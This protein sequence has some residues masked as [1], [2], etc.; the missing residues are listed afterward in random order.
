MKKL[1]RVTETVTENDKNY[2]GFNF[3]DKVDEKILLTVA[4]GKFTLKGIT[5]KA[6]RSSLPDKKPWQISKI[7][8]RLRLHG[9]I[10]KVGKTYK[11]Y[12]TGLGKQAIVAGLSFRNMSLVPALCVPLTSSQMP[13]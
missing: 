8:K 6:L 4:D 3:F 11:Y 10:K 9:L 5:N 7:L 12:L 1:D 2:K 13:S